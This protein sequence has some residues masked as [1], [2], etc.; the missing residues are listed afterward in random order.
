MKKLTA[1][2]LA[3]VLTVTLLSGC[4]GEKGP[5]LK[6]FNWGEYI[7]MSVLEDFTAETGIKVIYETYETNESMYTKVVN[8]GSNNSYDIVVPSEYMISKMIREGRLAKITK[9]NVPNADLMLDQF[10]GEPFNSF[11]PNNDYFVPYTWGTVGIVYDVTKVKEPVTSWNI[12]WDEKSKGE[13]RYRLKIPGILGQLDRRQ[14][15]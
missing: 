9:E 6:V 11:D 5:V 1:V 12:L 3:A 7:D 4:G 15:A 8:S 13:Y 10:K 2:L 14:R